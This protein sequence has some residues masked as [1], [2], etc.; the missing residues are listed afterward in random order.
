MTP[1][2]KVLFCALA[3]V[4][5]GMSG[6]LAAESHT[7]NIHKTSHLIGYVSLIIFAIAYSLVMVE[8][9]T[10]LRKSKPV[11]FAAGAA[12]SIFRNPKAR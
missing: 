2:L 5:L 4:L 9:F 10:H 11:L 7:L 1:R 6:A 3:F 8:E 12:A